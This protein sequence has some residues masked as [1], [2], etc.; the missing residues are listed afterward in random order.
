MG[1]HIVT[2]SDVPWKEAFESIMRKGE[3]AGDQYFLLL[4]QC[5]LSCQ[6]KDA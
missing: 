5:L 4:P 2:T 6:R 1:Q 3:D